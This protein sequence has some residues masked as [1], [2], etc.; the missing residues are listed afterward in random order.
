MDQKQPKDKG[1][2]KVDGINSIATKSNQEEME[3]IYASLFFFF[4]K[5]S[6]KGRK[7]SHFDGM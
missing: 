6:K 2:T 7:S 1:T 4:Y 5:H 3:G